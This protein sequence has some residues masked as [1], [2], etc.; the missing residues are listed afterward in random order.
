M[1]NELTPYSRLADML[2]EGF[3]P[4]GFACTIKALDPEGNLVLVHQA[5]AQVPDWEAV[6]M[7]TAHID[8]LREDMR[9]ATYLAVEE[10]EG[11]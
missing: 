4:V 11:D 1:R 3:M 7:L 10:D 2:P 8:D 5:T 9:D 6:G